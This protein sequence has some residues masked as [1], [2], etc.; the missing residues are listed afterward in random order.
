MTSWRRAP[1]RRAERH[2]RAPGGPSS[3]LAVAAEPRSR[4][5][6]V[7]VGGP[8]RLWWLFAVER[9]GALCVAPGRQPGRALPGLAVPGDPVPQGALVHPQ[10]TSDL[11]DR[12]T[13]LQDDPDRTGPELLVE[14]P[15]LLWHGISL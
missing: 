5:R 14:L 13:G 11:H 3:L 10:V 2:R 9:G 12:L 15:S 7:E 6:R 1:F 8:P 4:I